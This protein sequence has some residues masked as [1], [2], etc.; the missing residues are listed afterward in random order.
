MKYSHF[1]NPSRL[2]TAFLLFLYLAVNYL[3]FT[4]CSDKKSISIV[5]FGLQP[6][7]GEN[8]RP[9][10]IEAIKAC[11]EKGIETLIFPKGRY[12][13]YPDSAQLNEQDILKQ[14]ATIGIKL[15]SLTNFTL[16]GNASEFIYHGKMQIMSV[17]NS[18]NVTIKNIAIDWDRPMISQAEIIDAQ[19][20]HLDIR[21]DK[22][23][24]P[25]EIEN[26]QI[27][28]TGEGWRLPILTMY[29][30][31]YDKKSKNIA[32]NTWDATLGAIF[33]Q[34]AEEISEGIVRF[35]G[36]PKIKPNPAEMVVT[37]FHVRY[38]ANGIVMNHSKDVTLKD[39]KLYHALGNAFLG[40]RTE[41]VTMDN[42][43]VLVNDDKGRYF[44]SVADA[45]HFSQCGGAIKVLNC[46]HT[47]QADDFINVH[48]SSVKIVDIVDSHT[49]KVASEG[50]G[51]GQS[52]D[53]G[54]EYWFIKVADAQR[55]EVNT[56]TE[57]K[58]IKEGG[59]LVTF[60][61]PIPND[62]K[63]GDFIE[64]K[65]WTASL[66]IRN[67]KILKRNRAR[68]ILVTT[69][70]DVIIEDNYF[71]SAGTAILLEGDFDYWY[72]SGANNNVQIRNNVF[73]NCLTSGNRDGSRS[74]WGEAIITIT[75]SHIPQT[76]DAKAYHKNISITNN[77]FKIFDAPLVRAVS[78]D[79]LIFSHN[80]IVKTSDYK[81]YAWQQ[82]AFL[83][84]GCRNV[85]INN[86]K[87]D[88]AYTTRDIFIEHMRLT[89]IE[90]E[91]KENFIVKELS[92]IDTRMQW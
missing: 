66:E 34:R 26:G 86:N 61:E 70:K 62:I 84:D 19:D 54:D 35:Y 43:S 44:S 90:V 53:K 30:T 79:G 41:N 25:Y 12:D 29:S 18:T 82:S 58:K 40:H 78:T 77:T 45:S 28:F 22:K 91:P 65:T 92:N 9:Y 85:R 36:T 27:F 10:V 21:I 67:C 55:G 14:H 7:S 59:F 56:V 42:A 52:V 39:I 38:F 50:K 60:S 3:S 33:E 73:D 74:Q 31:L 46:A 24:Y 48:G 1:S 68:G 80:S 6:D 32:Y 20:T 75:P 13:F 69:P 37:L 8:A 71:S 89:D 83:L 49:I 23:T 15:D 5:E 57:K 17:D 51:S 87:I 2:R 76:V 88:E 64:C 16:E 81:P 11:K 63:A 47:G 72:E 4:A